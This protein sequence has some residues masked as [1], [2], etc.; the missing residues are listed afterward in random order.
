MKT[1]KQIENQYQ[2]IWQ[3]CYRRTENG[4]MSTEQRDSRTSYVAKVASGYQLKVA[5]DK[6][7]KYGSAKHK[8]TPFTRMEYAG[9]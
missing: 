9:Y 4:A 5:R 1:C 7:Y 8:N 6:G 3:E 2:K